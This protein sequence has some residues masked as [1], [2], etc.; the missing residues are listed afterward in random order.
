MRGCN[1]NVLTS[2]NE[3]MNFIERLNLWKNRINQ[4]N[5]LLFPRTAARVMDEKCSP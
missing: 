5:L 4:G 3:I 2:S 1:E